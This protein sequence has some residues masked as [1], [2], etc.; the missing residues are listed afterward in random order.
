MM[1]MWWLKKIYR[2]NNK[3]ILPL[4][5]SDV[6]PSSILTQ[7]ARHYGPLKFF[8]TIKKIKAGSDYK[9]ISKRGVRQFQIAYT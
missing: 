9:C 5:A 1:H 2:I 6:T 8:S 3:Q 7:A 4:S